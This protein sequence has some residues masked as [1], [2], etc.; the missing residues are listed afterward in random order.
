MFIDIARKFCLF[1]E[2]YS[3][4]TFLKELQSYL[5]ALYQAGNNLPEVDMLEDRDFEKTLDDDFFERINALV[6]RRLTVNRYYLHVVDPSN[7]QEREIV[8]GD[9][10]DDVGD[11]YKD[12][13]RSLA[14]F[15]IGS[16]GAENAAYWKFKWYFDHHWGDHC[17]NAREDNRQ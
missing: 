11:I 7:E 8:F 1:I 3:G 17:A 6:A 13:K 2:S 4:E 16:K 12:L 9:L 5:L 15:D 10:L 14:V